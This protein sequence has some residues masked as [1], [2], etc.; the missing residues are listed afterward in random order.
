M[1]MNKNFPKDGRGIIPDIEVKPSSQAI[2]HGIDP[3]VEKVRQL[4]R[5]ADQKRVS[6][7]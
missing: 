2:R 4:I 6:R 1:V 5:A 3:K 7:D